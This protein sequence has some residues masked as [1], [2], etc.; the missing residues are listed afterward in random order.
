MTTYASVCGGRTGHGGILGKGI[1]IL[2][3]GLVLAV[4]G[5]GDDEDAARITAREQLSA[6]ASFE[7]QPEPSYVVLRERF[8]YQ[9]E[10]ELI[11]VELPIDVGTLATVARAE[12]MSLD[13]FTMEFA[14]V[15]LP[16]D[17]FPFALE[18]RHV[19]MHLMVPM[20]CG[21]AWATD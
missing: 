16:T 5:C 10:E 12:A 9:G 11:W 15:E 1:G 19:K 4:S 14:P 18:L 3:V 6:P 21:A 20:T 8:T 7:I 13:D 2:G 17:I